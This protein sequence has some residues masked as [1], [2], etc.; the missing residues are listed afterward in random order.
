M[1]A[2]TDYTAFEHEDAT[3][4]PSTAELLHST[5]T[6]EQ[7]RVELERLRTVVCVTAAENYKLETVEH[8][9]V[10]G[11]ENYAKAGITFTAPISW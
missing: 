9:G 1:P 11:P 8:G 5:T 4:S 3:R 2:S 10:T 6:V 7:W